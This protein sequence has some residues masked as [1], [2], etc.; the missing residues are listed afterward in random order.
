[1]LATCC[2][3]KASVQLLTRCVRSEAL[4]QVLGQNREIGRSKRVGLI[5]VG[6]LSLDNF[7]LRAE[8]KS[9]GVF[10]IMHEGME[11]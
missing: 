9:F 4:Q 11:I 10:E 5:F 6:Y 7:I 8:F 1:M 2:G 3:D